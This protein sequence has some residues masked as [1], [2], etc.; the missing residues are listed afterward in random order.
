MIKWIIISPV[1]I[2][3][4][5]RDMAML[6]KHQDLLRGMAILIL[7]SLL[8]IFFT[9]WLQGAK[10]EDKVRGRLGEETYEWIERLKN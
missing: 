2:F 8:G 9:A 6:L 3:Y 10:R 4:L 5:L 1:L 7:V